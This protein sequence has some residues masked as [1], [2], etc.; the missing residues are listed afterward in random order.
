MTREESIKQSQEKYR[1]VR[2]RNKQEI[3]KRKEGV[4]YIHE[5]KIDCFIMVINYY[6]VCVAHKWDGD[7]LCFSMCFKSPKD[8]FSARI[9]KGLLGN[10][11]KYETR[12]RFVRIPLKD[13]KKYLKKQ[14]G[15]RQF[16]C[17]SI[18]C[19]AM[20]NDMMPECIRRDVLYSESC[21]P[22]VIREL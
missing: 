14:K 15:I 19:N 12:D 22:G 18:I 3:Q 1:Q 2:E 21:V 16:I 7:D 8:E 10:A 20:V 11:M 4:A 5:N 6:D 9:A 13:E 17:G